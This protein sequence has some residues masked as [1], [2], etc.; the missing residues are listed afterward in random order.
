MI[1][2][3]SVCWLCLSHLKHMSDAGDWFKK[4]VWGEGR[5]Q[6]GGENGEGREGHKK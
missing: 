3:S 4:A 1:G 5:G 6:G 2:A